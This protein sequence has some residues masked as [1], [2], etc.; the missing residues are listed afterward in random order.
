MGDWLTNSIY[1]LSYDVE[2][3]FERI[4]SYSPSDNFMFLLQG[5]TKT[6]AFFSTGRADELKI[7]FLLKL[8]MRDTKGGQVALSWMSLSLLCS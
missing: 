5:R 1:H 3:F 6:T 4:K 2:L 7:V 8:G